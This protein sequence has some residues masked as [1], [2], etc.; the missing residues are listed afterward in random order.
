MCPSDPPESESS[1]E[2]ASDRV[3]EP[4]SEGV[5]FIDVVNVIADRVDPLIDLLTTWTEQSIKSQEA[6]ASH[7]V[8]MAW[9]VV[10][11]VGLVV[12]VAA[13]LT[14][15]G[16][17]DGSALTFLLGLVVGYVLTFVRESLNPGE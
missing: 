13:A 1:V 16:K 5:T 4:A 10:S 12:V 2:V 14:Y 9:V 8:R 7:Q 11:V 17:L 6:T 15:L 3:A